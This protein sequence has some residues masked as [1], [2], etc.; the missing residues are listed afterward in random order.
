MPLSV[1]APLASVAGVTLVSLQ[2]GLGAEQLLTVPFRD[3][4]V[5]LGT[6]FDGGA[7]A[8]LDCAAVMANLDLVITTDTSI[9]HLAG[10]LGRPVWVALNSAADWR[11]LLDRTDS[12][13][14][15]SMRLF[16][17]PDRLQGWEPV[18]AELSNALGALA[19]PP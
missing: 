15:P 14:Y 2:K 17:Q 4:I 13:W 16:R 5:D 3:R 8:F 10:A 7:D 19:T 6:E 9:A 11:W 18:I 12:P 1:L